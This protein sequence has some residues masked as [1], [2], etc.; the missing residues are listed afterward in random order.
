[1]WGEPLE[2]DPDFDSP[3]VFCN[4]VGCDVPDPPV[5]KGPFQV[6]VSRGWWRPKRIVSIDA[7]GFHIPLCKRHRRG[8]RRWIQEED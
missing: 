2:I 5:Y 3:P 1:M 4:V 8:M 7:M 6:A